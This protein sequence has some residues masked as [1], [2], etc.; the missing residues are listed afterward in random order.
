MLMF[1]LVMGLI[2]GAALGAALAWA[3]GRS[4]A[5]A[6]RALADRQLA[7]IHSEASALHARTDE[8]ERRIHELERERAMLAATAEAARTEAVSLREAHAGLVARAEEERRAAGEKLVMLRDAEQQL[9]E[10]FAALSSE[11]L[12]NNNQSF[13]ELARETLG[14]FA[15]RA[16]GDLE[17]REQAIGEL[18]APIRD[19]LK[20]FDVKIGEIERQREGAYAALRQQLSSVSE[21]N[22]HL[23]AETSN[24]VRALRTPHVR[25]RWGEIQ[26]KRVVEIAGMIEHCDFLEQKT[27]DG[28]EGKLRPDLIVHLPG[29]KHV[30]V[31]AKAPLDAYLSAIEATGD[32]PRDELLRQHARQVRG[33]VQKLSS[34][35]YWSQFQHSP[36]FVLM[37]LPAEPF[38]SAALQHDP[39]LIE[40]GVGQRVMIAS[41]TT[42]IALLQAI[43]YGWRQEQVAEGAQ[44]I[45]NLGR[46]LYDRLLTM[47]GH[48]DDLRRKLDGAVEAY[49][50]T[51]ASL[52]TRVYA[53]ARRFTELGVTA[54][55]ELPEPAAIDR[56]GRALRALPLLDGPGDVHDVDAAGDPDVPPRF[57]AARAAD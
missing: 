31:D 41:P 35:Q 21:V 51:A 38:H 17:K 22:E 18:V 10:A 7:V 36:E 53:Q 43:A 46:A 6:E 54:T 15:E 45:S 2:I 1:A 40:Y 25:G 3:Y 23:R 49:N 13:L 20:Q 42:L 14:N 33:H 4:R 57:L 29:G 30:V 8:R 16:A 19:S 28:D 48:F 39:E 32:A 26:L 5:A 50:R 56:A 55:A 34:K 47:A 24:L 44:H 27:V 37:F 9:R 11:A 52:E 12:R